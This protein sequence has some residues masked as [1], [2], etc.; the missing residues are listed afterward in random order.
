MRHYNRYSVL[1]TVVPGGVLII[2][3]RYEKCYASLLEF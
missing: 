1:T 2:N 3:Y